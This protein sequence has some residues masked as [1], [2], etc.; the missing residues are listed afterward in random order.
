MNIEDNTLRVK[1][2]KLANIPL[3]RGMQHVLD[4]PTK[5]CRAVKIMVCMA[6]AT[7]Y[8]RMK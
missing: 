6:T 1:A 3:M 2:G 5:L 8:C 4:Q 7:L